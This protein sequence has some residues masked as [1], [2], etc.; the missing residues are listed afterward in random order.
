M[1]DVQLT[2]NESI[3]TGEPESGETLLDFLRDRLG[4]TGAKCGCRAGDCG[5]CKVLLDGE[6]VNSCTLLIK[7]L[8][9][10][11]VTTIEGLATGNI[12]HPVQQAFVEMGAI[13]CGFCTPGMVIQSVALLR[14][15]PRPTA[16]EIAAALGNNLCRCTG[17]VKIVRA[18]QRAAELSPAPGSPAGHGVGA[19]LPVH[20][21]VDKV[22]GRLRYLGDM[23]IPGMVYGRILF[24]PHA[25]ARVCSIDCSKALAMPGVLAVATCFN[26]PQVKYNSALRFERHGIPADELVF[27]PVV[28]FVGDRVAAVAATSP[29]IAARALS[30]LDVDYEVL[31][32]VFDPEEAL[33]PD[34]PLIQPGSNLV[35]EIKAEAGDLATGMAES[36]YVFT[37]KIYTPRPSHAA[38]E[39]HTCIAHVDGNGGLTVWCTTQNIFAFRVLLSEIFDIPM[40]KVRVIKPPVGGAFGGKLEM[41]IEP[42]AVA[43]AR[44]CRRPVKVELTRREVF[45]ATRTRHAAV[46]EIKTG[47]S[48]DGLMRAQDIKVIANTGAYTSSALNVLGAMS[49]KAFKQYRIPHMRCLGYPVLTNTPVAG[50]MRGYGSPQLALAREVHLDRIARELQMDPVEF[51]RR[52]LV[53]VGDLNP[54][55][56]T[57]LGNCYPLECLE[58]GAREFGWD[59][60]QQPPLP[61]HK[62]RGIGVAVGS[63]GNGVYPVHADITTVTIKL[64][65]DGT[66][67]LFTGA[68]DLGQGMTTILVQIASEV[69]GMKP[70]DWSVIEADTGTVPWDLGTYASRG[71]WVI[72]QAVQRCAEKIAAQVKEKAAQL[73]NTGL[74]QLSLSDG[75]VK[76]PD[77][78]SVSLRDVVW[79]M[80]QKDGLELIANYT[81][82]STFNPTSYGANYAEVEVDL[83]QKTVKVVRMVAVYDV[84]KAINPLL[85][86]GQIEGG[87]QMGI[88]YALSED[89]KLDAAGRA[90]NASLRKYLTPNAADMPALKIMLIEHGEQQGAYG[91]K[92]IGECA[93]VPVAPAIANAVAN[94]LGREIHNFPVDLAALLVPEV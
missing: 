26:T 9:G 73:L 29:K 53:H 13:Q 93:T 41:T 59:S 82:K 56:G 52:N 30:L 50:A 86:E 89:L 91:A 94:A 51:R 60:W 27:S 79:E 54:R 1:S 28:R 58:L 90:T 83:E 43:L 39:P 48:R 20:D 61:P 65:E 78:L 80:Q 11:S 75:Y 12:L 57:T 23:K 14:K 37:D 76:C 24:S 70:D 33:A 77:G 6:A 31:P 40:H 84:G 63:H 81:H 71:T 34:A 49:D 85:V 16:N 55:T 5:A 64:N 67:M 47:V 87:I 42:V 35:A 74:E 4:L 7:N 21:A 38:L 36:D 18:I 68:Q 17:Y 66:G 45:F 44:M 25:H 19:A 92:S 69:L 2:V 15:N 88:G 8:D 10:R 62:R 3:W 46:V 32:A 72:G 22:T